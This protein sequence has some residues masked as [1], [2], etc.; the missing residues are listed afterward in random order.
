MDY[1]KVG[2]IKKPHG[3]KGEFK[4]L[5]LTDDYNRFRKLKRVYLCVNGNYIQKEIDTVKVLADEI[6]LKLKEYD[7]IEDVESLRNIYIFIERKDG[8]KLEEWEYY[9]QDIIDC[10]VFY[11]GKIIGKV[12]DLE[13]FGANDN[14]VI[15]F[16]GTEFYY[17]FS[18]N[19]IDRIDIDKK[20]VE[21]NT[22]EDFFE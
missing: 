20:I 14:L 18:R 10:D 21:I 15:L 16:N 11:Q 19:Y 4:V 8:A 22:F 9:S 12:I 13:N 17:P 1:L 2:F 6:V 5:P 3:L 7:K